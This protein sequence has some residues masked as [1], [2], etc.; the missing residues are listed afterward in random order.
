MQHIGG[1]CAVLIYI[2]LAYL[3]YHNGR[4]NKYRTVVNA[5]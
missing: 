3:L 4:S 2:L 1:V 5:N